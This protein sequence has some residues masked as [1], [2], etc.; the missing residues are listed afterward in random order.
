MEKTEFRRDWLSRQEAGRSL[1]RVPLLAVVAGWLYVPCYVRLVRRFDLIGPGVMAGRRLAAGGIR[2]GRAVLLRGLTRRE[3]FCSASILVG[4]GPLLELIRLLPGSTAGSAVVLLYLSG[5][6]EWM[7]FPAS[8]DGYLTEHCGSTI[9][10]PG[11]LRFFVPWLF[12]LFGTENPCGGEG[13]G[14]HIR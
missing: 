12:V 11:H 4:Y 5:P 14:A 10:L 2:A 3:R 8:L 9:P 13:T 6:L 1:W 7:G